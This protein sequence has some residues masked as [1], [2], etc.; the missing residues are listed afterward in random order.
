MSLF[1]IFCGH[2]VLKTDSSAETQQ[3][4]ESKNV[5]PFEED[6]MLRR[7]LSLLLLSASPALAMPVFIQDIPAY[8]WYHGCGPTAAAS[9]LAYWDLH[10]YSNLFTASGNDL[11]LTANVQDQISSPA[12]NAKYDPDPDVSSLPVPPKTSI[13]D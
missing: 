9:V 4:F 6:T 10:G 7:I 1:R 5:E 13:A 11:Y 12:H 2:P 8:N 3:V